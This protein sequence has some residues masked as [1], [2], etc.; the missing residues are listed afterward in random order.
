[1][2]YTATVDVATNLDVDDALDRLAPYHGAIGESRNG[3]RAVFTYEADTLSEAVASATRIAETIGTPYAI[4]TAP[5]D[6]V[7]SDTAYGDI[8]PL[9]S[10]SEAAELLG[11]TAQAVNKRLNSGTLPGRKV[12]NTWVIPLHS[13]L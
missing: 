8:P 10:V 5:T 4:E 2:Q 13:V 6:L 9:V 3:Y 12:G 7:D 1:M 11:I